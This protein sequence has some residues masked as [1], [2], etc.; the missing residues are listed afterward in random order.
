MMERE[1]DDNSWRRQ[2]FIHPSSDLPA[3][4]ATAQGE[5]QEAER[6]GTTSGAA[7]VHRLWN[8]E[9]ASY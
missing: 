3:A 5:H 6:A 9:P 7:V 4:A 8:F 2:Q 1:E